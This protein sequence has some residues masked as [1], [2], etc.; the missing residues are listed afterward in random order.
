VTLKE[1]EVVGYGEA[2]IDF[3]IC[4]G[5]I[6]KFDDKVWA[7]SYVR[8][9]GGVTANFCVGL[10]RLGRKTAFMGAVGDD[11][12]GEEI[13]RGLK[14]EGVD[15]DTLMT[16]SGRSSP[17]NYIVTEEGGSR[18]ILQSPNMIE[19][20]LRP[21]DMTEDSIP[22]CR[23]FHTSAIIPDTAVKAAT[24]SKE[25]GATVSFD[26]ERHVAEMGNERIGP[27]LRITDI[28]FTGVE[29]L[30]VLGFGTD[31]ASIRKLL[32]Q[33]PKVVLL[34]KGKNG[35]TVFTSEQQVTVGSYKVD[36][37]DA[38]GAGDAFAAG[39]ISSFLDGGSWVESASYGNAAAAIKCTKTGA[40]AGLPRRRE[41]ED[42][43]LERARPV[44]RGLA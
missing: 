10:S 43:I 24:I 29:S 18:L 26:L 37:V 5:T 41:V 21:D 9:L 13:R 32:G 7:K 39:F 2:A 1:M 30:E 36:V 28:L 11:P 12:D 15:T 33:G 34:K 40:Q 27:L 4:T 20:Q 19:T 6:T 22:R 3:I 42:F 44:I 17:V 23:V 38:T 35:V 14:R 31:A 8:Q 25:R 16:L